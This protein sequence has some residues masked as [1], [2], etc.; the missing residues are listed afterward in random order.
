MNTPAPERLDVQ[1]FNEFATTPHHDVA[2][3]R[4]C[5][6]R[7][8]GELRKDRSNL[9]LKA[10][11]A[12]ALLLSGDRKEGLRHLDEICTQAQVVGSTRHLAVNIACLYGGAGDYSRAGAMFRELL[13]HPDPVML[14]KALGHVIV[15]GDL[16]LYDSVKKICQHIGYYDA[17]YADAFRFIESNGLLSVF[18]GH[19]RVAASVLSE[20]Q[21]DVN[22]GLVEDDGEDPFIAINHVVIGGEDE[23]WAL[24]ERL[25]DALYDFH[26]KQG[27]PPGEFVGVIVHSVV[28]LE[29]G[30][31]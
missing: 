24:S 15:S 5:A 9:R 7:L 4:R 13:E 6:F 18:E 16:A 12:G 23:R 25:F 8:G 28:P 27:R 22:W 31:S 3:L 14:R 10:G 1:L 26:E 30:R 29:T 17:D 11:L 21:V 2:A 19:Q 20:H